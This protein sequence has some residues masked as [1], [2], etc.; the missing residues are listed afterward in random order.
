M[1]MS[2]EQN[3]NDARL[4]GIVY[5]M[6]AFDKCCKDPIEALDTY[7]RVIEDAYGQS[8]ICVEPFWFKINSEQRNK[9]VS[10]M[11][12]SSIGFWIEHDFCSQG[13][14]VVKFDYLI[15]YQAGATVGYG[16]TDGAGLAG[17]MNAQKRI[18][19]LGR[20]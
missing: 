16:N 5:L 15:I 3:L 2:A 1:P 14:A 19:T 10:R 12:W 7:V 18:A 11:F 8:G 13:N 4:N 9:I 17:A 6:S 20:E